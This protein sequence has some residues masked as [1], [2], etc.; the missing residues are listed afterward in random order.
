MMHTL[1]L[2]A[3]ISCCH[4]ANISPAYACVHQQVWRKFGPLSCLLN[5]D[6]VDDLNKTWEYIGGEIGLDAATVKAAV[7]PVKDLYTV[8]DHTRCVLMAIED[9]SLPSNVGG[10]S[11][12][13]NILRRVFAI[14]TRRGWWEKLGMDGF[15]QIFHYHKQDLATIYG[16]FP[17]YKSFRP[18]IELEYTRWCTTDESQKE[19]LTKLLKKKGKDTALSLEDW[20]VAV[21]SWGISADAIQTITK[22]EIP[23]NLY[24]EIAMKQEKMVRQA[25]AQLYNTAHLPETLSLYYHNHKQYQFE[26]KILEVMLN[27][28]DHLKPNIIVLDQSA[29]YPTSGGQEH[30]IGKMWVDGVEYD[31]VDVMK[32]GPCVL[33]VLNPALPAAQ[34]YENYKGKLVRGRVDETRRDQLRRHHSATHIVYASCRKVLGPHVWQAGAKKTVQQAHLDITHFQGLTHEEILDIENEANRIVM[35]CKPVNKSFMPKDEAEKQYGFHLYQGGVVPGNEL[36]VV[37]IADTDT[38]ACCGTHVDNTSE[39]G[40]IKILKAARISD[41]IVRL[42]FVAGEQ[43]LVLRNKDSDILSTLT[44]SWGVHQDDII[45]TANRFFDGYKKYSSLVS[46]QNQQILDLQMKVFILD[47]SVKLGLFESSEPNATLFI[48][49]MPAF[50]QVRYVIITHLH[51]SFFLSFFLCYNDDPT[52]PFPRS[53]IYEENSLFTCITI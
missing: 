13:R 47:A 31:V 7:E 37:N 16:P 1:L 50:A 35:R 22:Q 21:T 26:G 41:G 4:V 40:Q 14:L 51:Y 39:V 30:D 48:G 2:A 10:A 8:L 3:H 34:S 9:G 38:E 29:F 17:D 23:L 20:I 18:V 12:I 15:L 25:P 49:N 6:E 42:Y 46:K 52:Q 24:Y 33:H 28:T 11:N 43:A 32:V 27:V 45:V 36:R 19:K 44:G 5:V 53:C